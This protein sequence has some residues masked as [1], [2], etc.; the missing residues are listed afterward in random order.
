MSCIRCQNLERALEARHSEYKVALDSVCY[1]VSRT[2]AAYRRVE[3]ERARDELEEHRSVCTSAVTQPTPL[4]TVALP[5]FARQEELPDD[6][7]RAVA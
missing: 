6:H 4:Q 1:R 3:L 5:R 2:F 7:F